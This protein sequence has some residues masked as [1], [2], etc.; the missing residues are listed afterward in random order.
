MQKF[1]AGKIY[2]GRFVTSHDTIVKITIIRRT[3]KTL[4]FTENKETKII[5][6]KI[7]NFYNDSYHDDHEM[8]YPH[9]QYSMA[10]IIGADRPMSHLVETTIE[11][12]K[13]AEEFR[14]Q[15]TKLKNNKSPLKLITNTTGENKMD[16]IK[17]SEIGM[18]YYH[19]GMDKVM[20]KDFEEVTQQAQVE[21]NF[22]NI[23]VTVYNYCGDIVETMKPVIQHEIEPQQPQQPQQPEFVNP[24]DKLFN[25][26]FMD[27]TISNL[28]PGETIYLKTD[29]KKSVVVKYV[30][31]N[32]ST[33]SFNIV[34][35]C[36]KNG[37]R[38]TKMENYLYLKLSNKAV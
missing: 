25:F 30:F 11:D 3:E 5:K 17:D 4:W 14:Q 26:E 9:G 32:P 7:H 1:E 20:L 2:Y 8:I 10:M 34:V 31:D 13:K 38:P 19:N 37:D 27:C 18:F 28:N 33:D 22:M 15:Q 16:I 6:K 36:V 24:M 29:P 35:S 23:Q 21:A 12:N